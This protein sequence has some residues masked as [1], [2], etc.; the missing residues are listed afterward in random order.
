LEQVGK[1]FFPLQDPVFFFPF[2][3]AASLVGT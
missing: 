1:S 3:V 2:P